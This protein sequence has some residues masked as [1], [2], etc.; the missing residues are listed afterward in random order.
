MRLICGDCLEVL[1]TLPAESADS[2]VTDPPYNLS[3]NKGRERGFMG[4]AWDN[5]V[6]FRPETWA[7]VA[8]VLRPGA[9]LLSF[10]GTRTFHR[11]ACAVE[12]AGFILTDTLCWLHGQGYPKAKS[13]LKPAWEPI[14]LAR[15]PSRRVPPLNVEACRVATS[16]A[17]AEAMSRCNSPGS[18]RL[19]PREMMYSGPANGTGKL[20]TTAGRWPANLVLDGE[21]A[22]LLDEQAG[23]RSCRDGAADNRFGRFGHAACYGKANGTDAPAAVYGDSGGPSRFFYCS[24]AS[25]KDRGEGNKHPTV[26]PTKLCEWLVRLITPS[27]GTVLDPFLGSGSIGVA[28]VRQ[29]FG[30]VGIEKDPDY[31]KIAQRRLAAAQGVA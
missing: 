30:F 11:V 7:A 6:A 31:F 25:R 5:G 24:K 15:K 27:G 16:A 13:C 9:W 21:A 29:G 19:R 20:D 26:K 12:D 8:R 22:R 18:G 3:Q 1:P 4:C 2:A 10:G 23:D 14:I 28:S 17:D